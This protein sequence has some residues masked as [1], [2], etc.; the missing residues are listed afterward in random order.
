MNTYNEKILSGEIDV[1]QFARQN[2][3]VI[4]RYRQEIVKI[5]SNI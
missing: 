4:E 1:Y 2:K 5:K 3:L